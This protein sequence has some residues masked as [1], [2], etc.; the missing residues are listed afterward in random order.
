MKINHDA[1]IAAALKE[2]DEGKTFEQQLAEAKA[3]GRRVVTV[4]VGNR[5]CA[6]TRPDEEVAYLE[7]IKPP[8]PPPRRDP[9]NEIDA[10]K[11]RLD[12]LE[13]ARP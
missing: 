3:S 9:I 10:L 7:S 4:T 11:A 12:A 13:R 6:I 2:Q 1:Q 5:R 8:P